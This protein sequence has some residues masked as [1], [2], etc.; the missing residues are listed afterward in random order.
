MEYN[1]FLPEVR[2]N[3][4]PYY[5]YLRQHAPAYQVPGIGFWAISR[6]DD[7]LYVLRNPQIFSAGIMSYALAGDLVPV[8]P[9][10][11]VMLSSDPPYHTRI[12]KL[13]NRA[14]T[15]RR[16]SSLEAH[17]HQVAQDLIEP[18][19]ARGECDLI[20]DL[21][22]PLP[23]MV[24]AEL[25][26]IPRERYQDFKRW[27]DKLVS[28]FNTTTLTPEERIQI[29]QSNT[30][31]CTYLREAIETCRRHPGDNLLSDLVRAEEENQML[32]ADE[33]LSTALLILIGGAETTT[34]L[35]GNAILALLDHPEQLAQVQADV[36]L[37]SRVIEETLRYDAPVH[38]LPR[39]AT[40][41]VELSGTTV[42][43]GAVVLPLYASANWDERKFPHP[44]RFDITR[45]T[46]GLLT[47]GFGIHFCLGAQLARMEAN[48]A[49]ETLLRRCAHFSLQE[50]RIT[51]VE[52]PTL[53][54][55]KRLPLAL[56]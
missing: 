33:V 13:A 35:L 28:S 34:N 44:E 24:I 26:G 32:T 38:W 17:L 4:Y 25:L 20:H 7:V 45:N 23:V 22:I 18:M 54:G 10:A 3:P 15:P 6:Y 47:F 51:R 50:D 30:E 5:T 53:R 46:E 11:P 31:L 41:D 16:V 43:A 37:V 49:L 36:T 2:D 19:L 29:Q 27:V 52:N 48:I 39:Q 8:P 40:Q 21:A 56:Q 1:P 42:P 55:P 12:R 9:E 14:F